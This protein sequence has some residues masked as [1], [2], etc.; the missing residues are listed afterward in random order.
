MRLK[1]IIMTMTMLFMV[2][3]VIGGATDLFKAEEL[4]EKLGELKTEADLSTINYNEITINSNQRS[5]GKKVD[6]I[7]VE[8]DNNLQSPDLIEKIFSNGLGTEVKSSAGAGTKQLEFIGFEDGIYE[9]VNNKLTLVEKGL[10]AGE[11]GLVLDETKQLIA[12]EQG[13]IIG[14]SNGI[15]SS[16]GGVDNEIAVYPTIDDIVNGENSKII[17][18]GAQ[19]GTYFKTIRVEGKWYF[20]IKING[21][22]GYVGTEAAQLIPMELVKAQTY[23]ENVDGEWQ[24]NTAIDPLESNEYQSYT[25]GTA[26]AETEAGIKYYSDDG[27]SFFQSRQ[28]RN[29]NPR[30]AIV[31]QAYFKNLPFRSTSNYTGAQFK[32]YLQSMGKTN[33]A[34]YNATDAF[35]EAQKLYGINSLFLFALANHESAFGTSNFSKQCNN[36]FGRGAF[37]STPN[38]A[39]ISYGF[40]DARSGILAQAI[41]LRN[42]Y[43]DSNWAYYGGSNTGDLVSGINANYATDPNWGNA[44]ASHMNQIDSYLGKKENGMY[45][46]I[47][48][49]KSTIFYSSSSLSTRLR[50]I[51]YDNTESDYKTTG[52]YVRKNTIAP[53]YVVVEE[54]SNALKV[55]VDTG[56]YFGNATQINWTTAKKGSYP[57]YT[58]S[59]VAKVGNG[60]ATFAADYNDFNKQQFWI[61]KNQSGTTYTLIN[62]VPIKKPG[63]TQPIALEP[64]KV[65]AKCGKEVSR[66]NAGSGNDIINYQSTDGKVKC[67]LTYSN[68]KVSK[69]QT[70]ESPNG[71]LSNEYVGNYSSS[72]KTQEVFNVYRSD[73]SIVSTQTNSFTNGVISS[74]V[75][76]EYN[77][78]KQ[79][80]I[81]TQTSY[82]NGTKTKEVISSYRADKTY[83]YQQTNNYT[84]GKLSSSVKNEYNSSKQLTITT[85]VTYGNGIKTKEV[86]SSFRPDKTYIYQQTN[87]YTNGKLAS[88]VKNE[89]NTLKQL[90]LNTQITYVDEKKTKEIISE[91]RPDKTYVYQ[92]T[93]NYTNGIISSTLKSEYNTAKQL[94][95]RTEETY[96]NGILEVKK[97]T[98]YTNGIVV[99]VVTTTYTNKQ[100]TRVDT[101]TWSNGKITKLYRVDY[102][103]NK[104]ISDMTIIYYSNGA[105]EQVTTKKYSATSDVLTNRV[106]KFDST[107]KRITDITDYYSEKIR[108]KNNTKTYKLGIIEKEEETAYTSG[109]VSSVSRK[110]YESGKLKTTEQFSYSPSGVTLRRNITTYQANGQKDLEKINVY[111]SPTSSTYEATRYDINGRITLKDKQKFINNVVV[112]SEQTRYSNNVKTLYTQIEYNASGVTLKKNTTTYQANGQMDLEKIN[113]YESPTSSTYVATRYDINGRITIKDDQKFTKNVLVDS[114]QTRYTN[115]VKTMYT[116]KKYS[117]GNLLESMQYNYRTNGAVSMKIAYK[118][119]DASNY[120]FEVNE[121]HP[122]NSLMRNEIQTVVAGKTSSLERTIYLDSGVKSTYLENEYKNGIIT[123]STTTTYNSS[124]KIIKKIQTLYKDGKP[125]KTIVL[126]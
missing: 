21:L 75:K 82:T 40:P 49:N 50:V 100:V 116:K 24:V 9:L 38:N 117:N 74:S 57:K 2:C 115:N 29:V 85:Q 122:N 107:K 110:L 51:N 54:T 15:F 84:N 92:L 94:V 95:L 13:K 35:V 67:T 25:I 77:T 22:E 34:Y 45:R 46:L 4:T 23:F 61:P 65:D 90:T 78:S 44:V 31:D 88:S 1:K 86:I 96:K 62:D 63:T 70:L 59:L 48:V 3:F 55:Q 42:D 111:E 89:Y 126:V 125:D 71:F 68:T 66:T 76:N 30:A 103:A 121:Y 37:D 20:Q 5:T 60:K 32:S 73:K 16:I 113:V 72:K 102:S 26:P 118:Y 14:V 99:E 47:Q 18:G 12:I 39:C 58:D 10:S 109:K 28:L 27:E 19:S 98:K 80:T 104:K 119:K 120:T 97:V 33:S 87:N 53:R 108:I 112:S 17:N 43:S 114:E 101:E 93:N 7:S 124:G 8:E 123:S 6:L 56:V 52:S 81:N 69:Y 106:E 64:F 36:F 11:D 105:W 83:I 91:F 41:F 79:L